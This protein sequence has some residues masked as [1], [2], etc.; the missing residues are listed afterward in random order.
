MLMM[1]TVL[2]ALLLVLHTVV[3]AGTLG[4]ATG[5]ET[6]TYYR[7]GEDMKRIAATEG[8]SLRVYPSKGSVQN[9]LALYQRDNLHLTISQVDVLFFLESLGN[10]DEKKLASAMRVVLP[11][12]TE[13]V[14]LVASKGITRF[15]DLQGKR[16]AVGEEGSGTAITAHTLFAL[17]NVEPAE[18]VW[19]E[20]D[21]AVEALLNNS[22]DAAI[23]VAGSPM[24]LLQ[25]KLPAQAG[26]DLVSLDDEVFQ[27][28][29]GPPVSIPAGTYAWQNG[30]ISTL[31]MMSL[32]ITLDFPGD[33]EA[34]AEIGQ[35][36]EVVIRE[37]D[38]LI[39]KGHEKWAQV[40]FD[41]PVD[42]ANR[43]R[44]SPLFR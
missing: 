28:L 33:S 36:A 34:C 10:A 25:E 32:L 24:K 13:E 11:L 20:A 39:S 17:A 5:R 14:H 12:Y 1:R 31:G 21:Q 37:R 18:T 40:D 19:L 4:I 16:V 26:V 7:F 22:I 6:G 9:L 41:Y 2:C 30:D 43:S 35:L 27:E 42:E 3:V 38:W 15:S 23:L 44:C 8:L 29:Y